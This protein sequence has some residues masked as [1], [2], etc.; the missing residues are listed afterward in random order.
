MEIF[1]TTMH[2]TINILNGYIMR[3]RKF[4]VLKISVWVKI[5]KDAF[6]N[7]LGTVYEGNIAPWKIP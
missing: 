4:L 7:V 6:K 1:W 3:I 2:D 5:Q